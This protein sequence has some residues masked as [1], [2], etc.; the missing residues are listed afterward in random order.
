MSHHHAR[1]GTLLARLILLPGLI[2]LLAWQGFILWGAPTHYVPARIDISVAPGEA[3]LLGRDSLAA[4][5]ADARHLLVRRDRD[6]TWWLGNASAS[7][8]IEVSRAGHDELIRTLPLAAGMS[9]N[10]WDQTVRILSAAD[11]RL[12]LGL[13]SGRQIEF[14]GSRIEGDARRD[15]PES[16]LATTLRQ[17]WNRWTPTWLRL[18]DELELGG[19]LDCGNRVALL[20]VP[21]GAAHI[22]LDD[23]GRFNLAAGWAN[24]AD[25]AICG[26]PAAVGCTPGHALFERETPLA[27][28][29]S[30]V[31]GRTQFDVMIDG[32]TLRLTPLKRVGQYASATPSVPAGVHW[33]MTAEDPWRWPGS[34]TPP[35]LAAL[36]LL[37]TGILAAWARWRDPARPTANCIGRA[38]GATLALMAGMAYLS[39]PDLGIGW[40]W[41][42]TS[43][44]GLL[45]LLAPLSGLS[46][47]SLGLAV[48]LGEI[49][50]TAL[51]TLGQAGL[52]NDATR[53]FQS[54]AA[55][56]AGGLALLY[57]L[58]IPPGQTKAR[59][60]WR[61]E[62]AFFALALAGLTGLA[63]QFF[64]G[65]ETGVFGIQPVELA[66]LGLLVLSAHVLA[67]RLDWRNTHGLL[68]RLLLWLRFLLPILLF[69][70]LA[71]TALLLV[72]DFSPL[73][74]I[75]AWAFATLVAWIFAA[76][77]VF[78][79]LVLALMLAG[80]LAG[81]VWSVDH[82]GDNIDRAIPYGDRIA[83]WLDPERHPHSGEQLDRATRL[84]R[85]GGEYGLGNAQGWQVPAIQ[86]DFAPAWFLA[87]FGGLGGALLVMLQTL[88]L[89]TLLALGW[90]FL[91]TETGDFRAV[92]WG[93]LRF[94]ALWGG[95]GLLLGHYVVSWGTNL[96]WLP[97]MGQ[98]SPWLS[99]GG[100]LLA[101]LL[102]PLQTLALEGTP[103]PK[104]ARDG[105]FTHPPRRV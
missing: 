26:R 51:L 28:I 52:D 24:G 86:D 69:L 83:V 31:A 25:S 20:N 74:L 97:V 89:A 79:G 102:I 81:A 87:R 37:L 95:A 65:D 91:N 90:R 58:A 7:H 32:N 15:C 9:V 82:Q 84:L 44:A 60:T 61:L 57:W 2:L 6:G 49:G 4:P 80:T 47:F 54:N 76:G 29:E 62:P 105:R 48:M 103:R 11:K 70:A 75:S 50:L 45:V 41:V 10:I 3:H 77:R 17:S 46:L 30:M 14:D 55:V 104:R 101:F 16:T 92:W 94:F 22:W 23:A 71:T 21:R 38:S 12:V 78:A 63:M 72:H 5:A 93:R 56:F 100:S 33:T 88:H 66:K 43:M 18:R 68:A 64:F 13:P 40:S 53:F 99:Y 36:A 96:G 73:V 59:Q 42:L 35:L 19:L 8:A 39:G 27:E 98:P 1:S 34:V 67:L 85:Q